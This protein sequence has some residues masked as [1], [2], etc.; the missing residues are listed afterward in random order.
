MMGTAVVVRET[1]E[2]QVRVELSARPG[3]IRVATGRPFFDHMLSTLA[4]YAGLSVD[5]SA[6]GDLVHHLMEDVAIAF[7]EAFRRIVPPTCA[8]YGE[9]TLPMDDVLVQAAVDLGG[10]F[11]YRGQL[12]NRLY[13]HVM[14]SFAD[15]ARITLHLRLLR[16][17]DRHHLVEACFKALGLALRQALMD[18]GAVFSTKGSVALEI[19][20]C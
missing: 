11:Y 10:R 4:R 20:E 13:R 6:K 7:G 17:G 16:R 1:K 18:Q 15:A 8:R 12:P 3:E 9:R 2:T 14:R 19:K 5:L